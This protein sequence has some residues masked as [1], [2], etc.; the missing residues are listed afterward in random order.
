MLAYNKH[1]DQELLALLKQSDER[2]MT[3]IVT[4]YWQR[5]LAVAINRLDNQQE[6]EEC[7]QDVF[8]RFWRLRE[9]LEL[10]YT[11]YTYLSTA[12]RYRIYNLLDSQHR[13]SLAMS[14][15]SEQM[16]I[17]SGKFHADSNLLEKE[18]LDRIATYVDQLPEKCKI[19]YRLHNDNG[20]S[21]EQIAAELSISEKTVEAH[22]TKA[23]RDIRNNLA[24]NSAAFALLIGFP[25]LF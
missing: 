6:A 8:V 5:I 14:P 16:E 13:K 1:S 2:A 18:L 20:L 15:F 10:R 9:K 23:S 4:R 17:S 11:L 25:Q 19:V 24:Q 3:E 7:V 22:L 21:N 12:V